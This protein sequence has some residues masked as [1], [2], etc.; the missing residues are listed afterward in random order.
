MKFLTFFWRGL[1]VLCGAV[2]LQSA[3]DGFILSVPLDQNDT[4]VTT[5]ESGNNSFPKTY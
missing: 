4:R 1:S 3:F 5:G 2:A